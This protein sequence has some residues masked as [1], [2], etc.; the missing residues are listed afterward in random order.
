MTPITPVVPGFNLPV[1]TY[2][3]GQPEY[4]PLPSH[5]TPE[6]MV[7]TRWRLTWKERFRVLVSGDLWLFLL[8]FNLPLQPVKLSVTCPIFG[9]YMGDEEI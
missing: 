4:N 8:T 3:V 1:T 6:V 2:A 9:H 5:K 7:T